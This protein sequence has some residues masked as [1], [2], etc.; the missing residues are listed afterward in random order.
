MSA[1]PMLPDEAAM[2]DLAVAAAARA[3]APYSRFRVGVALRLA[4]GTLIPG[5][6]VENAT[7]SLTN[8]AERTALF[9]A[10]AAGRRD[11][12]AMVIYTDT[13]AF[14]SPCGAC[15]QVLYELA[16]DLPLALVYRGRR[17]HRLSVRELL[18]H[19]FDEAQLRSGQ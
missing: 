11:F 12:S 3:H 5:C 19:A 8:C 18:P 1:P 14:S 2:I 10:I 7:Y 4:D 17:V 16:P 6:N 13:P 15:R 9:A